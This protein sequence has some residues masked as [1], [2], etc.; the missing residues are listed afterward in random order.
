MPTFA[1]LALLAQLPESSIYVNPWK[2]L[3]AAVLFTLWVLFAQWVDKDT[4][5]VNTYRVVW[6]TISMACGTVALLLLLLLPT[7][8]AALA[9]FA[10][11]NVA[12][13]TAYVIH[14]NGLVLDEDKV[15]TRAHFRRL[16]T[17]GFRG[18]KKKQQREVK[19]RVR[20]TGADREVA[21]AQGMGIP[22]FYS[23]EAVSRW[24]WEG[25]DG[26]A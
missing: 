15:C 17:E 22:V 9:A 11:I 12:F 7:Y 2:L 10:V 21:F 6:N 4:V 8:V 3:V 16:M 1:L 25:Q 13:A 18:G 14:R 24:A 23:R 5:A 19:E 26:E 20:I